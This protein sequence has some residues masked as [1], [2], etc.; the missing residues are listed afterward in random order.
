[1]SL[2]LIALSTVARA[3][4]GSS[5]DPDDAAGPLDVKSMSHTN[6]SESATYRLEMYEPFTSS[7]AHSILWEFD[8][9]G[10]GIPSE[11]CIRFSRLGLTSNILRGSLSEE[12]GPEVWA[13]ADAQFVSENAIEI[14]LALIDLVECCRLESGTYGYRVTTLDFN[15]VEDIAPEGGLVSH[16]GISAPEPRPGSDETVPS[17]AKGTTDSEEGIFQRLGEFVDNV[18]GERVGGVVG[19]VAGG[20]AGAFVFAASGLCS[21]GSCFAIGLGVPLV[22]GIVGV[23]AIRAIQRRRKQA[24]D[25]ERYEDSRSP[26]SQAGNV[27]FA[28]SFPPADSVQRAPA[29][30][31]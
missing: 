31:D 22:A 13:T 26:R 10:D 16:G 17:R 25:Q 6:N 21:G 3:D 7:D 20:V 18:V 5:N 8:F 4:S 9:N 24:S 29:D 15:G 30:R 2:F 28:S 1:M 12:C 11:G 23:L 14:T 27:A 19:A